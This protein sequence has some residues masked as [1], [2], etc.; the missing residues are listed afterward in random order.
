MLH[1]ARPLPSRSVVF[2]AGVSQGHHKNRFWVVRN[3]LIFIFQTG[4][5]KEFCWGNPTW[6]NHDF[7]VGG[8]IMSI[9][10]KKNRHHHILGKKKT[11]SFI[12]F[13]P[14]KT[15]LKRSPELQTLNNHRPI[16]TGA[17]LVRRRR[18][19]ANWRAAPCLRK[20]PRLKHPNLKFHGTKKL[21]F[22]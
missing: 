17:S 12:V 18:R 11:T 14:P 15:H 1:S 7:L 19:E 10:L 16:R 4:T 20:C 8:D 5:F 3:S 21:V 22:F 9:S 2:Q 13:S 6:M